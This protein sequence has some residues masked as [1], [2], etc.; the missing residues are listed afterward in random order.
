[1]SVIRVT[2]RRT[3]GRA[4]N[5]SSTALAFGGFLAASGLMF[6]LGIEKAE[7]TSMTLA[8]VW[9][10]AVAPVLPVLAAVLSMDVWS[11]ERLSRRIDFLLSA[12]VREFDLVLGKF[13]GVWTMCMV[14]TFLSLGICMFSLHHI[15]PLSLAHTSSLSFIPG[16]FALM[17]QSLLWCA[18]SVAMSVLFRHAAAAACMSA[19]LL[20]GLPRGIWA[21]ALAWSPQGR[22]SLGEMPLDAHVVDIAS[23]SLPLGVLASYLVLTAIMLF[24]CMKGV[25]ALRLVGNGAAK[26][27]FST[28][29]TIILSLVLGWMFSTL[30]MR[31]DFV[32][33]LPGASNASRLSQRTHGILSESSGEMRVTCFLPRNDSR[34]RPV[35]HILR[36]LRRE[37][38][39][40][41]GASIELR[42]VDPRWD[43][44]AAQR[45][46]RAGVPNDSVVFERGRRRLVIPLS[47]GFNERLFA[48]AVLKLTTPQQRTTVYW[49][50]GHGEFS[51]GDYGA[52]GMSD[53]SRELSRDGFRSMPLDLAPGVPVPSDCA[54]II[55]AGAKEDFSRTEVD[56]LDSYLKQGG[57]MLVLVGD[58]G[59]GGLSSLLSGWGLRLSSEPPIGAKTLSGTDIIAPVTLEHSVTS[60]L[61]GTQVV[62]ERPSTIEPSAASPGASADGVEFTELLRAGGRCLAAVAERGHGVGF[63]LALRPTRIVVIGDSLF[64]ANGQLAARGNANR[65]FF[66]NCVAYLAGTG[67]VMFGGE[68]GGKLVIGLDR[69]ERV[70]YA[71]WIVGMMPGA[72][73][74]LLIAYSQ[75]RRRRA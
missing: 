71:Q 66:L 64:V 52:F 11:D 26:S 21:A 61:A 55:V 16:L 33:E 18:V 51:F 40:Q 7:G 15:E 70:R 10:V 12:P 42:Y 65:D 13:L 49:T 1:M 41:G 17:V 43:L 32:V 37:A 69:K 8:A 24:A 48:S 50:A 63:D 68:D 6:A 14:A 2:F 30:A 44:G 34:F 3:I 62:L 39:S 57:R 19:A 53:V 25:E 75:M 28:G 29:V 35:G 60:P 31:L 47:D 9:A 59:D 72:V 54:L 46:V 27:R 20:C 74:L 38:S 67:A 4:R 58:G 73:F 56:R 22:V 45:L 36:M 23:G 5:M